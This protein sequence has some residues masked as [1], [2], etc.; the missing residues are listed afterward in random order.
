MALGD[1]VENVI[2]F[3][4]LSNLKLNQ[5]QNFFKRYW[6]QFVHGDQ[7]KQIQLPFKEIQ[8]QNIQ[9]DIYL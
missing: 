5:S 3:L 1:Q 9:N 6:R 2:I 4:Q 7:P 8:A